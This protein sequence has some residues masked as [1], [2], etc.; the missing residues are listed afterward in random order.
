LQLLSY[1]INACSNTWYQQLAS[2]FFVALFCRVQS[3]SVEVQSVVL[4]HRTE[5]D[6]VQWNIS[7]NASAP[8]ES[9][10]LYLSLSLSLS[11]SSS[12]S[13]YLTFAAIRNTTT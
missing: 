12:V 6:N 13:L 5:F 4:N 3:L 10:I 8:Q 1:D 11:L 7:A 2:A 9:V